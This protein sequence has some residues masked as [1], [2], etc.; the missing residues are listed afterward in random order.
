MSQLFDAHI[1]ITPGSSSN[2]AEL[3]GAIF[4]PP[5]AARFRAERDDQDAA[6]LWR[7]AERISNVIGVD[8][9]RFP[10]TAPDVIDLVV[11]YAELK[12][13]LVAPEHAWF[14]LLGDTPRYALKLNLPPNGGAIPLIKKLV[15]RFPHTRFLVDP[16][17]HGPTSSWMAQLRMAE[18]ENLFLTTLGLAPGPACSWPDHAL[19]EEACHVVSGEVGAGKLL[20]AS[21]ASSMKYDASIYLKW[22]E[23][24]T[25]FDSAQRDL[26][27]WTNAAEIFKSR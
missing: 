10:P 20:F 16:F 2:S 21:G 1:G 8:D 5:D 27:A 11:S 18:C 4:F 25:S 13:L 6:G 15:W 9:P 24:I 7:H 19:V 22:L 26:V 23:N 3:R 17:L 14:P 12:E